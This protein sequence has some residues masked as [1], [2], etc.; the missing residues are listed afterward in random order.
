MTEIT[1]QPITTLADGDVLMLVRIVN[2]TPLIFQLPAA[3][4]MSL[5][6]EKYAANTAEQIKTDFAA[7]MTSAQ[8]A[9]SGVAADAP[10]AKVLLTA[11]QN[12][13]SIGNFRGY[14][15]A[16]AN[17]PA[18]ANGVGAEGDLYLVSVAGTMSLDG[19]AVWAVGDAAWFHN[20]AWQFYAR[21]GW[22]AVAQTI[23]SLGEIRAGTARMLSGQDGNA[24]TLTDAFGFLIGLI[25]PDGSYASDQDDQPAFGLT[26]SGVFAGDVRLLQ[27]SDETVALLDK[28]GF[29]LR[30]NALSAPSGGQTLSVT[31]RPPGCRDD[32]AA[33]YAAA[34][35][36]QHDGE[37]QTC[38]YPNANSAIWQAEGS[39]PQRPGDQFSASL[40]AAYG[41]TRQVSAYTGPLMDVIAVRGSGPVVVS[42]GQDDA[43]FLSRSD[44]MTAR[45]GVATGTPLYVV[46][47]Y[48]QSSNG[49]HIMASGFDGT[50]AS[51]EV[52]N[53]PHIG[54]R[55][56]G[57]L[58]LVSWA[59]EPAAAQPLAIPASLTLS[60][61]SA[62]AL[63]YG[64]VSSCNCPLYTTYSLL[65]L[66]S[67]DGQALTL[68]VGGG[69]ESGRLAFSDYKPTTVLAD[70]GRTL[71]VRHGLIGVSL[72]G[73]DSVTLHVPTIYPA[74]QDISLSSG[75]SARQFVGGVLGGAPAGSGYSSAL[76]V[77]GLVLLNAAVTDADIKAATVSA[78]RL[79][80]WTPQ[81]RD[82]L[83]CFGSS[84][85]QGYL[86]K[87]GWCWPQ[88]LGDYLDQPFEVRS[89]SVAGSK[90]SD[91]LEYTIANMLADAADPAQP[92][93]KHAITWYGNNDVNG[94]QSI[95][96]VVANNATIHQKLRAAGY[97]KLFILGQYNTGLNAAIRQAVADGTIDADAFID[98]WSSLPMS[99]HADTALYHDGT[100]PTAA[101][102]RL[103]ASFI[104]RA[105]NAHLEN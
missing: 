49:H 76:Q 34:D 60:A 54:E 15:D 32:A 97:E 25:G 20:G 37:S 33:L 51:V 98:P 5:F 59:A 55:H 62:S 47:L 39:V 44:L 43:G 72:G 84:T 101:A 36:W 38:L 41:T 100:H 88:M 103:A 58:D 65:G 66:G 13:S 53:L 11:S 93:R 28:H 31:Q 61:G 35:V 16:H 85:T 7:T 90:A 81:I 52:A 22:A 71:N 99:N 27:S 94:G 45:A 57:R 91:F 6:A 78:A 80:D 23:T 73:G 10:A 9:V 21:A 92:R 105:L 63:L 69:A 2:N 67:T 18:L 104:A 75:F 4:I 29:P 14:W 83:D 30:L 74:G 70:S 82:R 96:T 48:D 26:G 64:A 102:D 86:N 3:Q 8:N 95:A 17:A 19:N 1:Q 89:V 24:L 12:G 79:Y 40:A 42:I 46:K 68:G 87:D 77:S 56:H 50:A